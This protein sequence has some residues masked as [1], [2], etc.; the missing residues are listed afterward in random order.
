MPSLKPTQPP[1]FAEGTFA[2]RLSER[3]LT[4]DGK[5]YL[6]F[7][8]QYFPKF[9]RWVKGSGEYDG[10]GLRDVV[11]ANA[12]YLDDVK[13]DLDQHKDVDAARH[14]ALAAR[15]TKLEQGSGSPPFPG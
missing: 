3:V 1:V 12:L 10:T 11:L 9:I 15:V 13:G 14:A 4:P 2:Q 8:S 6:V 5:R 7:G